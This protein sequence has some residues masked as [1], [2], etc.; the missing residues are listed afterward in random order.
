MSLTLASGFIKKT[1][2]SNIRVGV[3]FGSALFVRGLRLD[4]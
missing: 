1:L 2:S 3:M 4:F